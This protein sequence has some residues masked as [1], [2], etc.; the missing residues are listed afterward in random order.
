MLPHSPATLRNREPILSILR[1]VLSPA[2]NILEIASGT[3][4]H[5]SYFARE[6]PDWTFLPTDG[7]SRQ[8]SGITGHTNNLTNVFAPIHLDVT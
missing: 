7:D 6:M 3:G 8:L 5:T 4:E 1:Q 2:G